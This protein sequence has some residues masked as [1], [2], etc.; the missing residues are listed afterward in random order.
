M[1]LDY[2]GTEK[3]YRTA[4]FLAPV[5]HK[6]GHTEAKIDGYIRAMNLPSAELVNNRIARAMFSGSE[7]NLTN[8]DALYLEVYRFL[9]ENVCDIP[10]SVCERICDE[11]YHR[12]ILTL[13]S[14]DVQ[15]SSNVISSVTMKLDGVDHDLS[16]WSVLDK[17]RNGYMPRRYNLPYGFKDAVAAM[18]N[19]VANFEINLRETLEAH[20]KTGKPLNYSMLADS[21]HIYDDCDFY[22][23]VSGEIVDLFLYHFIAHVRYRALDVLDMS[24]VD[25]LY[26]IK[27]LLFNPSA[28][29]IVPKAAYDYHYTTLYGNELDLKDLTKAVAYLSKRYG[30]AINAHILMMAMEL[31]DAYDE[32]NNI[33][34]KFDK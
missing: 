28:M 8:A 24:E 1:R 33:K 10:Y 30:L 2:A 4:R 9:L 6:N 31:G 11:A 15:L 17:R 20:T 12:L 32:I 27:S 26:P 19:C 13:T 34:N 5:I 7:C 3:K 23:D 16:C 25:D 18:D 21:K 14:G 22:S 29:I